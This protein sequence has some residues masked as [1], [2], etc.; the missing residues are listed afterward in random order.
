[1]GS[2]LMELKTDKMLAE[3]DDGIGWVTY[4]NPARRNAI[5]LEM[6]EALGTILEKLSE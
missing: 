6:W 3:V 4:N 2:R 5:S 1:M